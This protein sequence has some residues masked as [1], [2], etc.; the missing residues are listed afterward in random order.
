MLGQMHSAADLMKILSCVRQPVIGFDSASH[1]IVFVNASV[2]SLLKYDP[3]GRPLGEI[4][5]EDLID[6]GCANYMCGATVFGKKAGVSVVREKE[7]AFLFID[8]LPEEK[9]SLKLTGQMMNSLRS[10]AMGI[11]MSADR[12]FSSRDAGAAPPEKP[13]AILYHYYYALL[14][15]L[16][17]IDSAD[18]LGRGELLFSPVSTDL[19]R[20]CSELTDS[21]AL[22]CSDTGVRISF[23]AHESELTAVV[24]PARI[25]QLLLSLFANSLQHTVPGSSVRLSL[26]LSGNRLVFSLDDDGA[27]IPRE[28]L[29]KI[30]DPPDGGDIHKKGNGLGLMISLGIAQLHKGVLLVESREGKGTRVRVMLPIGENPAPKFLRAETPDRVNS[31][32]TVLTAL[33]EVFSSKNY[34]PKFED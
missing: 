17:Q 4:I 28:A 14:H 21:V 10:A 20:L 32:S 5:S 8:F 25:E 16:V 19:V 33:S 2:K 23:T 18:Q 29:S 15:T 3:A 26:S 11:K 24:D 6:E 1:K 7:T 27:G 9:N 13:I 31:V 34:G 22:F 12:C 30:F